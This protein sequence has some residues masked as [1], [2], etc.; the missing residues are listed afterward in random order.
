[1]AENLQN[2]KKQKTND[3]NVVIELF[4]MNQKQLR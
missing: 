3:K 2:L 1:M 4:S